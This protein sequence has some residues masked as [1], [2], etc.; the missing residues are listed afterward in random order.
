MYVKRQNNEG[1]QRSLIEIIN[2]HLTIPETSMNRSTNTWGKSRAIVGLIAGLILTCAQTTL[3]QNPTPGSLPPQ[4]YGAW[5]AKWWQWAF[6]LP[7]T[8][9]PTVAT[10][11]IDCTAGQQGHVY[12]LAGFFS[13]VAEPPPPPGERMCTIPPG[14]ALFFPILN[15]EC[16]NVEADPFYGGTK[17]ERQ[18][19][20]EGLLAGEAELAVIIDGESFTDLAQDRAQSRDFKFKM[21]AEDNLLGLPGVTGGKSVTDGYWFFV[22]PLPVGEHTIEI[23]GKFGPDSPLFGFQTDVIYHLTV[24]N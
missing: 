3:A 11:D 22:P 13:L 6:S 5:G 4:T 18:A 24:G 14:K 21:P 16:S 9:N 1:R 2:L 23:F 12:F 20:V 17:E 7:A 19:C 10:G 15:V 8:D